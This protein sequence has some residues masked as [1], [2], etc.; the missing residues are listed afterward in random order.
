MELKVDLLDLL[1]L[2]FGLI[3]FGL[4]LFGLIRPL[5]LHFRS[6]TNVLDVLIAFIVLR[7]IRSYSNFNIRS[8]I[9]SFKIRSKA[10]APNPKS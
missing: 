6:K 3:L 7:S 1:D 4:I 8:F 9:R 2:L 10:D 5:N